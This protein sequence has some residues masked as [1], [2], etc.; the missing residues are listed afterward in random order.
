MLEFESVG[1]ICACNVYSLKY[2]DIFVL[3]YGRSKNFN[4]Y[5]GLIRKWWQCMSW[6]GISE[7]VV[8]LVISWD[9]ILIATGV[10]HKAYSHE[11]ILETTGWN[12]SLDLDSS[13]VEGR[14][15]KKWISILFG[16]DFIQ[17][18][19]DRA[20]KTTNASVKNQ[21]VELSKY[22]V[23]HAFIKSQIVLL[24]Q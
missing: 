20:S 8:I 19:C 10:V 22:G 1:W 2:K 15:S 4:I 13:T 6:S 16:S 5:P 9:T 12:E 14:N 3:C 23:L 11:K 7:N 21:I 18:A 17:E 24:S